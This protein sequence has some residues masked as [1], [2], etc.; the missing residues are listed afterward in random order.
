M[1]NLLITGGSGLLATNWISSL[2]KKYNL[3]LGLHKKFIKTRN[4][5]SVVISYT[6]SKKL[7]D[8]LINNKIKTIIHTAGIKDLEKC[9]KKKKTCKKNQLYIYQELS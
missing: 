6:C 1:E 7:E 5:E 2:R 9:Q 3:F 8:F 4:I